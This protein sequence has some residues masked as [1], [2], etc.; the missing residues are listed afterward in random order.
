MTEW[1]LSFATLVRALLRRSLCS[2]EHRCR[3]TS[4]LETTRKLLHISFTITTALSTPSQ[5]SYPRMA[6]H[7][8]P[9]QPNPSSLTLSRF[10][11]L[12][13]FI[14]LFDQAWMHECLWRPNN[15]TTTSSFTIIIITTITSHHITLLTHCL[16]SI[17]FLTQL[18][19]LS[20][21]TQADTNGHR[22]TH[23]LC[24]LTCLL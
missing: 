19:T 20:Q 6:C 13:P 2:I 17:C 11:L 12:F 4:R 3:S 22:L 18:S 24:L 15:N 9:S 1:R 16:V 21:L 23:F 5:S 10:P 8:N 14:S 7:P